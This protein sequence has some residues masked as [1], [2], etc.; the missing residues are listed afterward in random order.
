MYEGR[1]RHVPMVDVAGHPLGLLAAHNA[2]DIDAIQLDREL[3]RREEITLV[4]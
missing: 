1:F 4:L 2:L 3:V